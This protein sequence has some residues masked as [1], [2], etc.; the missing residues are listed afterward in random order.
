MRSLFLKMFLWFWGTAILTALALVLAFIF[1]PQSVPSLWYTTLTDTARYTG[2]AAIE[3]VE[4]HGSLAGTRYLDQLLYRSK[5]RACLFDS[6][7]RPISGS[8]CAT[9][10]GLVSQ[11]TPS[12]TVCF[13]IRYGLA[14]MAM[15]LN[16]ADGRLY[17]FATELPAGPRAAFGMSHTRI[18]AQWGLA[19]LVSGFVCFLLTRYLTTPIFHLRR[20]AQELAAG[21]LGVRAPE[22]VSRRHD[23][24]GELV[25]D[26]NA[27]AERIEQ[28]IRQQQQLLSDISHE[29]RSPLARLVVALDLGRERKGD[30]VVF[31]HM[32]QDLECLNELIARLLMVAKLDSQSEPIPM[33][34]VN[35]A[36]LVRWIAQDARFESQRRAVT[37]DVA[38]ENEIWIQGNLNLL[39]S[40]FEN[41][42]RNATRYTAPESCVEI[43]MRRVNAESGPRVLVAVCDQGPGV[44]D[45]DLVNIF[46]PFYRVEGARDRYSGGTGLGL[47]IADRIV[48]LHGGT[49]T[50][51]N[52]SPQGLEVNIVLPQND[53]G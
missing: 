41:V 11:I 37:I 34:R 49:I 43:Q 14:R 29:L 26:F 20:V 22:E 27:M 8:Q 38:A 30:D 15:K 23:E 31:E 52:R 6:Q 4:A 28:L 33:D 18:G 12:R 51:Q 47:A 46:R 1:G 44:P 36:E 40:A 53:R 7:G 50:A 16:G 2:Q 42:I 25:R 10:A 3:S 19:F 13:D 45:A 39:R 24:I 5:L 35:L 48:R 21:N 32:E 17:T 9:L